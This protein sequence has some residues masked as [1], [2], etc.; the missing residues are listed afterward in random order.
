MLGQLNMDGLDKVEVALNRLKRHEPLEG[1]YL[2]FSGGKDSVVIKALCDMAGV[3]YDAHYHVSSV[4]PPELVQF[5]KSF[6]DVHIEIPHDKDGKPITMWSLIQKHGLPTRKR[7]FCCEQLKEGG[8]VTRYCVTG[9]RWAESTRRRATRAGLEVPALEPGGNFDLIGLDPD[10]ADPYEYHYC[11]TKAKV[12]L[13][14][15]IDW[16]EEDVWEFI[17]RYKIRYCT[18]YDEGFKR[19]GCIGCPMGRRKQIEKEF[20]RWPKYRKMYL[21]AINRYTAYRHARGMPCI[22]GFDD[23]EQVMEW[24]ISG[25]RKKEKQI[26]QMSIYEESEGWT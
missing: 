18:L 6:G 5:V 1:Y 19:L 23:P 25:E 24:W 26:E 11:P 16:L 9:V 7:R 22:D 13:N 2:A 17:R 8:G 20:E 12:V 14:P 3:K 15:I 21:N 4:D 10:N